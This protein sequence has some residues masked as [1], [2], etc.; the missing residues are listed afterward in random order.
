MDS[1]SGVSLDEKKPK[2][3]E[4]T[5]FFSTAI[6]YSVDLPR[7]RQSRALIV[8]PLNGAFLRLGNVHIYD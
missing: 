8:N 2:V 7:S 4:I 3:A 1:R 6:L 5:R